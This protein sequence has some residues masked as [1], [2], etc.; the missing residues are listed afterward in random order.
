MVISCTEKEGVT[1]SARGDIGSG[2][3]KL[4]QTTNDNKN[5]E[6]NAVTIVVKEPVALTFCCR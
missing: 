5:N 4:D 6:K 1:F 3:V 2:V